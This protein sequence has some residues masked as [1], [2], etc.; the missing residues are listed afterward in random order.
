MIMY[1]MIQENGKESK[2]DVFVKMG[3]PMI[4]V[5]VPKIG[6]VVNYKVP[7][8]LMNYKFGIKIPKFVQKKMGTGKKK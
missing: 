3:K 6:K 5:I 4:I 1:K 8:M 2:E 7:E